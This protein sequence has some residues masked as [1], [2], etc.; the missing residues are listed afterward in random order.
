MENYELQTTS[1]WKFPTRGNWYTHNGSYRGNWSPHIPRNIILKYSKENDVVL[2]MFVGSGTTLIETKLLNRK[3]IGI[4][5]NKEALLLSEKNLQFD[6]DTINEQKLILGNACNLDMLE[7]ESIDLICTHP[8]YANII[9]YSE[10][11][12]NDI[13]HLNV[14]EFLLSMEKVAL[15][16]FRILKKNKTCAFMIGDV[17]RN[18]NVIPLGFLTLQTFQKAGF[19][20]KEI[21]IKEQFNCH[22][23]NY[24][25][26]RCKKLGFYL[27]AH[28]Y[29]FILYKQ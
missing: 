21:I 18:G 5:I 28:E 23:T 2:D 7:N 3:G 8:P 29:I 24:W 1:I 11:I 12:P 17:R 26:E 22:S 9:K 20:L 15:E 14:E 4:D 27:L 19:T 16:S 6:F 10:N 25:K 13:S